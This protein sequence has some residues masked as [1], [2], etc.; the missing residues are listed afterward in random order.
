MARVHQLLPN[1]TLSDAMGQAA[2]AW[3]RAL[4]H[5]GFAGE[6][7]AEEVAPGLR[8]LVHPA[9]ELWVR[10]DDLVL[11]HHGIAS[12]LAGRVMHLPCRRGVVF[13]NVTP[14]RFY[15]GTRLAEP[16]VAGRAQLAA[17]ADF[18]EVSI[19]VSRFNARELEVAGHRNVHVVPLFVEPERFGAAQA[20]ARLGERLAP[21]GRPRV[22][23]VS[24][25]VPHKRMED[26]LALHE[27]L[28]RIAPRAELWIVGGYA[29]GSAAFQR[30]ERRARAIGGVTF[31]GRV[32]HAELVA[33]YRSADVFVSMSEHEGFGVPLIEA[34]A[35]ELPVLAFGAAAVPETMGGR[36]I[37]FDEKHF[38]GLAEL[39]ALISSD[40]ELRARLVEGQRER[41]RELSFEAT[42]GALRRALPLELSRPERRSARARL[43]IVVQRYGEE[44]TG[45]AE[46]HARQVA[47]H[48]AP[49]VDVEVLTTCATD[50]LTWAN[51]LDA[52]RSVD[53]EI[54]VHR[55]P[56]RAPR[57]MR[58]F[59]RLSD[60]LFHRSL[61]FVAE[62][63]WLAEQGPNAPGL[64]D[65][66]AARR[67]EFDAF[68]FFTYLYAPTAWGVPL[69]ADK[70][71]VVPTAHD[72]PPLA[73]EALR[74]VFTT[75]R[76][77]M[78]NTPEEEAMI[79][80]RFPAAARSRVTGVG[81]TPLKPKPARFAE[82]FGLTGPYLLYLGRMEAGK[83]VSEL[84]RRHAA[85]VKS[86]HDA[87]TL[88][89]AGSGDLKPSGARVVYAGRIDEQLK[90]DGLAG[91]L[92][93]V[94][95][96]RYES[97][98]LV[99]LEAFSVGTPVLG[100][101]ASEVVVGQLQRS[102]GGVAF[103][104]E[105]DVSF[106]DAVQRAGAERD[107]LGRAAKKYGAQFRWPAVVKKYLEEIE[108]IRRSRS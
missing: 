76:V 95:P 21:A 27:E 89:L 35:A 107:A 15:E 49:H 60:R 37:V 52:G 47:Q 26:L 54:V 74:D 94:V 66:I 5:L 64:L 17:L 40:V 93:V 2:V 1:F 55:F 9:S 63:H 43:A 31:L 70:A 34:M 53:G 46:A 41:V 108:A 86:F 103:H 29:P 88:V 77:L 33:A 61:D 57:R 85:L 73:F 39:V 28:R 18:V 72:E 7:Y 104:L 75:P 106:R 58:E 100:N 84:L 65:A 56:V 4:R 87:P 81:I 67:D 51:E 3:Q 45:G 79:Q 20:D 99:T 19:G 48:L 23:S 68:L 30:L 16:L 92:A 62:T 98:S 44:I 12:P 96:S 8:S 90:W 36:G 50:H 82:H 11:Y 24:R 91:A 83:G 13:H 22:V 59:N 38:A 25:V 10:P 97:L 6:L 42:T 14:A 32:S 105:S 102:G 101:A 71:L 69:V 80:R 78:T